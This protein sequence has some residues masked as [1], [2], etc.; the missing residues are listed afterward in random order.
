MF[1]LRVSQESNSFSLSFTV[2]TL[3][4][5]LNKEDSGE[6]EMLKIGHR[7]SRTLDYE[8]CGHFKL[9]FVPNGKEMYQE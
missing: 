8:L 1:R 6:V 3:A 4:P 7:G 9:S 5:K 2:R